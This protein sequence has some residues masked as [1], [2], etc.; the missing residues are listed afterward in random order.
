MDNRYYYLQYPVD[1]LLFFEDWFIRGN[2]IK[3]KPLQHK[4]NNGALR[5][6]NRELAR[7]PHFKTVMY[8]E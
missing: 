5:Y 3:L 8:S 1:K 2:S 4:K 7:T 6:P